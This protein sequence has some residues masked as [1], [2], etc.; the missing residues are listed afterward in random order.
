MLL[1]LFVSASMSCQLMSSGNVF[2][3]CVDRMAC[4][5]YEQL[6]RE[7]SA[8]RIQTKFRQHVARKAYLAVR[9]SAI[10]LQTGLRTMTARNEFRLKK[11]T[12]AAIHIQV[13]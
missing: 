13:L 7:A 5:Q 9:L 1:I 2:V 6:R 3:A 8:L 12:K 4:N 11:R 10:T